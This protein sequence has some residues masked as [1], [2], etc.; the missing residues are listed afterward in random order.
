MAANSNSWKKFL[1]SL[2]GDD[3]GDRNANA[4]TA[5]VHAETEI[6]KRIQ[7]MVEDP[8]SVVLVA[9]NEKRFNIIHSAKNLGGRMT[10]PTNKLVGLMGLGTSGIGIE[11]NESSVSAVQKIATPILESIWEC[12]TEEQVKGLEPNGQ[13]IGYKG[14]MFFLPAP[15]LRRAIL[16]SGLSAPF[17]LIP[18]AVAAAKEFAQNH[19]GEQ[20]IKDAAIEH[21]QAFV[22]YCWS[23]GA[24]KIPETRIFPRPD[25]KELNAYCAERHRI[26]ILPSR[27]DMTREAPSQM[28]DN[29][30]ITQC[31][32]NMSKQNEALE[33][34]NELRREELSNSSRRSFFASSKASSIQRSF[35]EQ[36][37]ADAQRGRRPSLLMAVQENAKSQLQ[38]EIGDITNDITAPFWSK[39]APSDMR[40]LALVAH[41]H[42]EPAMYVSCMPP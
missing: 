37:D 4:F 42:M 14:S 26:C 36:M 1:S 38:L 10:R 39:F 11:I 16:S 41:N 25:D 28:D 30:V 7:A 35:H 31:S 12:T 32:V 29:S 24:G 2:P 13:I 6:Q 5:A 19:E 3:G 15:Y 9:D 20:N 17:K 34:S 8:N 18:V 21:A 40:Q 33:E 22:S 27:I 23:V